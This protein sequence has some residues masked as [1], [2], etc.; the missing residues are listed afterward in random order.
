M[1]KFV[2]EKGKDYNLVSKFDPRYALRLS[3]F[4]NRSFK[5]LEEIAKTAGNLGMN[6]GKF[7]IC[8]TRSSKPVAPKRIWLVNYF[9]MPNIRKETAIIKSIY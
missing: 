9:L 2:M 7:C 5:S 3:G 8:E 1:K 6:D 4:F